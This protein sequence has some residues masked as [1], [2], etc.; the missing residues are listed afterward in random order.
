MHNDAG[1][2]DAS[3]RVDVKIVLP[4]AGTIRI[5]SAQLFADPDGVLCR[6]FVGRAFL[7]AEID[8]AVIATTA[9]AERV[10]PAI[11]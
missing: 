3:P 10:T 7:A 2:G 11:Q 6:R 9:T 1:A 8:V 5:E 4:D